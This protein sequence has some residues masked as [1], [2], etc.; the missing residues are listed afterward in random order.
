M[1][2]L[3]AVGQ[4]RRDVT[5]ELV[6]DQPDDPVLAERVDGERP[7]DRDPRQHLLEQRPADDNVLVDVLRGQLSQPLG[8]EVE[9]QSMLLAQEQRRRL[10]E[11]RVPA[12]SKLI[13]A[14]RHRE[15]RVLLASLV[16]RDEDLD[17]ATLDCAL[18]PGPSRGPPEPRLV[19]RV[20]LR[21]LGQPFVEQFFGS[22]QPSVVLIDL[23]VDELAEVALLLG[24]D[25]QGL[26]RA[27]VG[28]VE[29]QSL[30]AARAPA[31]ALSPTGPQAARLRLDV[32]HGVGAVDLAV[33]D[34]LVRRQC[35][36]ALANPP[37]KLQVAIGERVEKP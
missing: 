4:A 20:A 31:V 21:K 26:L 8:A 7:I 24:G 5:P 6:A 15:Q 1:L 23:D 3:A 13:V 28:D 2:N 10:D 11:V 16:A 30:E 9:R 17:H 18:V 22:P 29:Q 34:Q 12:P 14:E 19:A 25:L 32:D 36:I 33:A 27:P 35:L 37:V